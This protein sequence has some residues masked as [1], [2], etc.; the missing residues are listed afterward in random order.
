MSRARSVSR[1]SQFLLSGRQQSD[2]CY[3]PAAAALQMLHVRGLKKQA[4][5]VWHSKGVTGQPSSNL[6]LTVRSILQWH[7]GAPWQ[8]SGDEGA[9]AAGHEVP[10]HSGGWAPAGECAGKLACRH[11]IKQHLPDALHPQVSGLSFGQL[12]TAVPWMQLEHRSLAAGRA[13]AE[14]CL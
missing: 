11:D 6:T 10:A 14:L 12:Q 7:A 9:L 1:V 8:C 3:V 5:E 2:T 13:G 4:N